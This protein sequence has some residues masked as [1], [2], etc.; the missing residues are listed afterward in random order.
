MPGHA[1]PSMCCIFPEDRTS[2]LHEGAERSTLADRLQTPIFVLLD[3]DIGMKRAAVRAA[4]MGRQSALRSL[5]GDD[6]RRRLE[7][8]KDF[9]A[10]RR[11]GTAFL[12]TIRD[13]AERGA[14]SPA[15]PARTATGQIQREGTATSTTSAP[16]EEIET[17]KQ[18]V[19]GDPG[20]AKAATRFGAIYYGLDRPGDGR[21]VA[22]ARRAG[23]HLDTLRIRAFPFHDD[24][25]DFVAAH[26]QVFVI[27]QNRERAPHA[28]DHRGE[29]VRQADQCS[30]MTLAITAR[31]IA[32]RSPAASPGPMSSR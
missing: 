4:P 29:I 21:G 16:P 12:R 11:R 1:T 7:A 13:H 26:D 3:L 8:G 19:R 24:V 10:P 17:A 18:L 22:N 5:A 25:L 2:R 15:A 31:F 30:T 28:S 9:G 14:S 23:L 27:E 20:D 32:A 6:R